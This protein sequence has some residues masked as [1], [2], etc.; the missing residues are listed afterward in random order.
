MINLSPYG[1][2]NF[3]K[4]NKCKV[5][6]LFTKRK[7]PEAETGSELVQYEVFWVLKF[8]LFYIHKFVVIPTVIMKHAYHIHT[9]VLDDIRI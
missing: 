2:D 1:S 5:L 9:G 6:N 3:L 7:K 8:L 4:D